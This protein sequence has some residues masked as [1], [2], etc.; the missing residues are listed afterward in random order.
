MGMGG[1]GCEMG[2][3]EDLVVGGDLAELL[4]HGMGGFAADVGID[5]VED[6][7]RHGVL[8]GQD[9]LQ[10]EHDTGEL[11]A[12]SDGAKGFPGLARVGR[13]EE[14]AIVEP[15]GTRGGGM[16]MAGGGEQGNKEVG[17]P[18]PEGRELVV[19][20]GS[21]PW[22]HGLALGAKAGPEVGDV[23]HGGL[24][25]GMQ[26]G[27]RLVAVLE[28]RELGPCDLG[29]REDVLDGVAVLATE[30]LDEVEALGEG[31]QT[32]GV[33]VDAAGMAFH[34]VLQVEEEAGCLLVEGGRPCDGR[35]EPCHV[36]ERAGEDGHALG[37]GIVVPG[38]RGLDGP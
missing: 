28:R 27:S 22:R 5:L 6:E 18:E 36:V 12:G 16:V 38:K 29:E 21:K 32:F 3:A 2:D 11:A 7:D 15:G 31:S 14:V 30:G 8:G 20:G 25:V 19:G 23:S 34:E 35:V 4:S 24:D 9:G 37:Q 13:E 26:G 1:D 17:L 10:G 33:E